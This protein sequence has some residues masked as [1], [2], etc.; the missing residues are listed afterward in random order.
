VVVRAP[1]GSQ[2]L[3]RR[4]LVPAQSSGATVVQACEYDLRDDG[5]GVVIRVGRSPCDEPPTFHLRVS[6]T[7]RSGRRGLR[8]FDPEVR[9]LPWEAR[10]TR[11]LEHCREQDL[12][13]DAYRFA[14]WAEALVSYARRH[15]ARTAACPS[16]GL[17]VDPWLLAAG[18]LRVVAFDRAAAAI[19]A[20]A[21][22]G[23]RRQVYSAAA[24]LA[25]TLEDAS[26]W[27]DGVSPHA[28]GASPDLGHP[29]VLA[30][31]GPRV[32]ALVGDWARLPLAGG[33]VDV[34]FATNALPREEGDEALRA[35]V[36]AEWG[37]VLRPGGVAVVCMHNA[38]QLAREAR[39][40]FA[41]RGLREVEVRDPDAPPPG[42]AGAF[43]VVRSSG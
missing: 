18:G 39:A 13:D 16:V 17:N 36:L 15:G 5:A 7:P 9:D 27:A 38:G 19:E 40:F 23:R 21:H 25:W 20:V 6:P 22:P 2:E 32:V 28:F 24:K 11:M 35:A 37:R 33:A 29:D 10:Y 4:A 42:P 12:R 41:A 30:A 1:W 31:L 26:R 34:L 14:G 3:L 8:S 43:Q